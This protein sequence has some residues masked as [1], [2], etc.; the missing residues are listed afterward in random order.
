M[1]TADEDD[2]PSGY[3]RPPKATR[4]VKGRSG[5]PRVRPKNRHR[6]IA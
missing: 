6:A 2:E 4:F 5:N 3:R 1:S